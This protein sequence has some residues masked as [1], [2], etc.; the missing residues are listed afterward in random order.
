VKD[1]ERTDRGLGDRPGR[2]CEEEVRFI[3]LS[4]DVWGCLV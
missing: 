1:V 3:A 2:E 4:L